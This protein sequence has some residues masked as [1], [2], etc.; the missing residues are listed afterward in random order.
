MR[1][2]ADQAG[3]GVN[4]DVLRSKVQVLKAQQQQALKQQQA[5]REVDLVALADQRSQYEAVVSDLQRHN[6]KLQQQLTQNVERSTK[7]RQQYEKEKKS[8]QAQLDKLTSSL[9]SIDEQHA[10]ER[11]AV[12]TR[13]TVQVQR[14]EADIADLR[15]QHEAQLQRLERSKEEAL[16]DVDE[17]CKGEVEAV[18]HTTR[19]QVAEAHRS[20]QGWQERYDEEVKGHA[21]TAE[22]A[23][24]AAVEADELRA[25]LSACEAELMLARQALA[26]QQAQH[27]EQQAGW[28]DERE[29]LVAEHHQSLEAQKVAQRQQLG[30]IEARLQAVVAKKDSVIDALKAELQAVYSRILPLRDIA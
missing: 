21:A 16:Q 22:C 26:A 20:V 11:A 3:S 7:V 4:Y 23:A 14:L 13:C 15:V 8:L 9:E 30:G 29:A 6:A 17:W 18:H 28:Q 5:C 24:Q 10:A 27:E 12:E 25:Q 1:H 19:V 2:A